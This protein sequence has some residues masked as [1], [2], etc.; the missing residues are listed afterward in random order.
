MPLYQ[1]TYCGSNFSTLGNLNRHMMLHDFR[2]Q[3]RCDVCNKQYNQKYNYDAHIATRHLGKFVGECDKCD[4]KF[5]SKTGFT[6]H[7]KRHNGDSNYQ[8]LTCGKGFAKLWELTR[9]GATHTD[10][11]PF[12]CQQC[13]LSFKHK[14]SLVRHNCTPEKLRC[15]ECQKDFKN[16]RTLENHQ[17]VH[18]SYRPYVCPWCG[19][20]F[21][22][23][24]SLTRHSK[25][26]GRKD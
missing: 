7:M 10:E 21:R 5:T 23:R 26:C 12:S 15:A 16:L 20:M 4:K 17:S 6:L 25:R 24:Y 18:S 22:W 2:D 11:K 3:F 8:C 9:H 1:C 14:C 19:K 13:K